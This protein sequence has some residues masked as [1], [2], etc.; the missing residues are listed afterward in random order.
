MGRYCNPKI[1][2]HYLRQRLSINDHKKIILYSGNIGEKQNLDIVVNVAEKMLKFNNNY[3]FLLVGDG[4]SKK[5]LELIVTK[6]NINNILF[7]PL[8]STADFGALLTMSD[9]HLVPQDKNIS[10]YVLP[11]K[12]TNILSAGGVSII[13][14]SAGTQL[15]NIA[16][17]YNFGYV[18]NPDSETELYSAINQLLSDSKV[19]N[20]ISINARQY[21]EK[22]LSKARI[23]TKFEENI[24]N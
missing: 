20:E 10:D 17:E 2:N 21:A 12:L 16:K 3:I 14:A 19:Y 8:Q 23:L 15:D 4:A 18:I 6:R 13:S 5:R 24:L 9:L 7:L 1:D 22:Y 11:S